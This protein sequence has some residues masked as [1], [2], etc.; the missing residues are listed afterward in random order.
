MPGRTLR[1]GSAARLP[2][3]DLALAETRRVAEV[4]VI[5]PVAGDI[6]NREPERVEVPGVETQE[7]RLIR[8][9]VDEGRQ[10]LDRRQRD[11]RAARHPGAGADLGA[12]QQEDRS[13]LH[14]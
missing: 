8:A 2:D 3:E 10:Q 7:A 4:A 6:R 5:L 1:R 14:L 13:A 12:A 9:G 11:D